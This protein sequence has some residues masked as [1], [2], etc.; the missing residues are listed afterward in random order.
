[1]PRWTKLAI[2][3][4]D[5]VLE[6]IAADDAESAQRVAQAIRSASERLDQFPQM[7]RNGAEMSTKELVVPGLP[8]ILIYRQQGPAIQILR[9]LHSRQKWP[10]T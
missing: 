3:D 8:Y 6:Y 5:S 7:G 9:L 2:R 10:L 1:M 4:L